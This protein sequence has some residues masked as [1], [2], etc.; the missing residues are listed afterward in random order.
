M[1]EYAKSPEGARP[2]ARA[3]LH[4]FNGPGLFVTGTGTDVGKTVVAAALA[5][6]FHRL[7]M[8]VGVCKPVASGCPKFAHRGND[9]AIPL[10]DD[11]F[12]SPDAALSA[13]AAGLDPS[14]EVLLRNLSP[15]RYA[16]PV[17]PAA[18]AVLEERPVEWRRV[19]A[20]LEWW[21]ENCEV[22]VVEGAGGWYSPLDEHD[23]MVAD[24]AAAL[25]LPVL[26]VTHAGMGAINQTLL[27][28][29]AIQERSLP[30]AGLV[31]NRVAPAPRRDVVATSNLDLLPRLSGVPVRAILPDLGQESVDT[32]VPEQFIEALVPFAKEWRSVSQRE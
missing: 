27:T 11:D 22:L 7:H 14:D 16:I 13:R 10:T 2:P 21:Q 20:A 6:A 26:V 5:G 31:I 32:H 17:T 25:K 1:S 18:A 4:P 15:I 24:L 30:V 28:I 29:H 3:C 19:E 8:R 23:F 9:P 12:Q